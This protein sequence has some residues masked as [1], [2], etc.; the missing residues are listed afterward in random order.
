VPNLQFSEVR[1]FI[2]NV[3][4]REFE[5][6]FECFVFSFEPFGI[7]IHHFTEVSNELSFIIYVGNLSRY[8]FFVLEI[9]MIER[10]FSLNVFKSNRRLIFSGFTNINPIVLSGPRKWASSCSQFGSISNEYGFEGSII[11]RVFRNNYFFNW[12]SEKGKG[13]S[14]SITE[15]PNFISIIYLKTVDS[16][17][18]ASIRSREIFNYRFLNKTNFFTTSAS[19][20]IYI[21]ISNKSH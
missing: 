15:C 12:V 9:N 19:N 4:S 10:F 3:F 16:Q 21:S 8:E 1:F 6:S 20:N 13:V 14:L 17:L 11:N 7:Q 18:I 5:N 2:N